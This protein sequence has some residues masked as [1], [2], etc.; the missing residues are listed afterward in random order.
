MSNF[1]GRFLM[2]IVA[3]RFIIKLNNTLKIL[4]KTINYLNFY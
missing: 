4:S 3:I 1:D 2:N